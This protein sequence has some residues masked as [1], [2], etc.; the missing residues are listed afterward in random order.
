MYHRHCSIKSYPNTTCSLHQQQTQPATVLLHRNR[1]ALRPHAAS[2]HT[3]PLI[4]LTTTCVNT[5]NS[6]SSTDSATTT[7]T[8]SCTTASSSISYCISTH[9]HT[10]SNAHR[11]THSNTHRHTHSNTHRLTHINILTRVIHISTHR[12]P[13][14]PP[15]LHASFCF[16]CST[17]RMLHTAHRGQGNPPSTLPRPPHT[18]TPPCPK[19]SK[20][21]GDVAVWDMS[22]RTS[23]L[24]SSDA[25][26][27]SRQAPRMLD[28][29]EEEEY[30]VTSGV[31]VHGGTV[32]VV[33]VV[34]GLLGG[35][36]AG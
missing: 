12:K 8:S 23:S 24:S 22:R 20:E 18:H 32:V 31:V 36:D 17:P 16:S 27:L 6:N 33:V 15:L 7:M 2:S 9:R 35:D 30:G 19:P 14:P 5:T 29:E 1:H 3:P 13:H 21:K 10:H 11:H 25:P 34:V 26:I 4:Y 28:G